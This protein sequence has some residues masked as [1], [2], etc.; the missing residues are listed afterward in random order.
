MKNNKFILLALLMAA[1]LV[2]TC[3][4]EI[5]NPYDDLIYPPP[6][7]TSGY[8]G[9][10]HTI[11]GLHNEIF[12]PLCANSGC[13]DGTLEPDYRTVESTYNTLVYHPLIK[14]D[15]NYPA[16][17]FKYRVVPGNSAKSMLWHRLTVEFGSTGQSNIMPLGLDPDEKIIWFNNAEKYRAAIKKWIDEGAKDMLGNTA[18]LGSIEPFV[19]GVVGFADGGTTPLPTSNG[20]IQVPQG[21]NQLKI[22]YSINDDLTSPQNITNNIVK[23]SGSV[24]DFDSAQ[25]LNLT[26]TNSPI[27]EDGFQ[28]VPQPYY[29]YVNINVAPLASDSIVFTRIYIKDEHNDITEIPSNG[30]L[31]EMIRKFGFEIE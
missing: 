31:F 25:S 4:K 5:H 10:L 26:Y 20:Y 2:V 9:D 22:W 23:L 18:Q 28:G 11:I 19:T 30:T 6:P 13:H 1:M 8:D 14:N 12:G 15:P 17:H 24:Y 27:T 21:T 3:K 29:H 7:D 16:D